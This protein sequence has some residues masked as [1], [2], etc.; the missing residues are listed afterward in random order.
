MAVSFYWWRKPEHQEK[1]I[2]LSQ[3][4]GKL[5]HIKLYGLHLAMN[6]DQTHNVIGT[7]CTG[8]CKSNYHTITTT[9]TPLDLQKCIDMNIE[10]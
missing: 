5:Y 2:D 10:V 3:V 8:S 9:T 4:T 6:G 7:D 1:T